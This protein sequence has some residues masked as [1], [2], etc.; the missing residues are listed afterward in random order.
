MYNAIKNL[1]R[2]GKITKDNIAAYV[3]KGLLTPEE[4]QEITGDTY[5]V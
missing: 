5:S 4:Y 1:Y 3:S 2:W